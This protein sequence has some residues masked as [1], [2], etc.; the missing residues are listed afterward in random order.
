MITHSGP[1]NLS[2]TNEHII[3]ENVV[4]CTVKEANLNL[5]YNPTLSDSSG[6]I[7]FP[8]VVNSGDFTAY[9]TTLGIYNDNNE[10]LM[11]AKFAKPIPI[12]PKTDITFLIKYDT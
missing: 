10:L 2:F 11:V 1:F 4:K 3:Y 8:S 7:R 5:S 12:S 6:S 9:A